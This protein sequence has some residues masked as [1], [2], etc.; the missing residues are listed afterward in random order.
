MLDPILSLSVGLSGKRGSDKSHGGLG[1][2]GVSGKFDAQ[3]IRSSLLRIELDVTTQRDKG[4]HGCSSELTGDGS[5][6]QV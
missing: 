3:Q 6:R 1:K 5:P 2:S 4:C